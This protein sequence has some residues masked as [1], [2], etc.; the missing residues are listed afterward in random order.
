MKPSP[1]P[2]FPA[3]AGKRVQLRKPAPG[4]VDPAPSRKRVAPASLAGTVRRSGAGVVAQ[5]PLRDR[6][7][8]LLALRPYRKAEL[9]L[10]LQRDGLVAAD[11]DALDGLLQQLANVDARDST[12]TLKDTAYRDV[13]RDWPGYSDGDQQLLKRVL[14]R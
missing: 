1:A 11:R 12:C 3:F 13:Q 8:H 5:K 2:K 4:A 10:R 7:L 14:A 6:V 9:L